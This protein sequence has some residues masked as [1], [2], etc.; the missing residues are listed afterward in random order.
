MRNLSYLLAAT[1]RQ[2][3]RS[4]MSAVTTRARMTVS[5]TTPSRVVGCSR[6]LLTS[7]AQL[8]WWASCREQAGPSGQQEAGSSP[9]HRGNTISSGRLGKIINLSSPEPR[10]SRSRKAPAALSPPADATDRIPDVG[11]ASPVPPPNCPTPR[12]GCPPPPGRP[13]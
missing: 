12:P 8:I 13:E 11:T 6:L 3:E 2:R 7:S 9:S 10:S 4:V 5:P 1:Q